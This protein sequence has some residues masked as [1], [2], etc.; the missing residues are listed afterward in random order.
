MQAKVE[1]GEEVERHVRG[2][3]E[4]SQCEPSA[5]AAQQEHSSEGV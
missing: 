3:D 4:K 5:W 1:L 2:D